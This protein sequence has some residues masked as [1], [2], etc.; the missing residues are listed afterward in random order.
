MSLDVGLYTDSDSD[1]LV[2]TVFVSPHVKLVST[3]YKGVGDC[4]LIEPLIN[5]GG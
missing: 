1:L 5:F 3:F 2:Y 4:G